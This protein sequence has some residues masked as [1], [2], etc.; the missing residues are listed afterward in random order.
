MRKVMWSVSQHGIGHNLAN[1]SQRNC[2][3]NCFMMIS[4]TYSVW[5]TCGRKGGLQHLFCGEI[6]QMLVGI[7][8]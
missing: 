7:D 8:F 5:I 4:N 3:T 1:M 2:S 6:F